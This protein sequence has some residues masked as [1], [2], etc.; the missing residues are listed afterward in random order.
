VRL[1]SAVKIKSIDARS[2]VPISR[3]R[4]FRVFA[5]KTLIVTTA[6]VL[7]IAL[8][9]TGCAPHSARTVEPVLIFGEPGRGDGQ[10]NMPRSVDFAR[11]GSVIVMDR[12]NRIQRFTPSG[13][14]LGA[15]HTETVKHGNPRGLSVAPN[16]EVFVADTHNSQVLVY[17]PQGRIA[18]RWGSYGMR[19]GQFVWVTD[20]AVDPRGPVYTCEYGEGRAD[21]LQKFDS[22]GRF[23]LQLARFGSR[24]GEVQR[25]QGLALDRQGNLYVADAVNH[26]VQEFAPD[27][28]L[29]AVIGTLGSAPGQLR[30]PYD[31]ALDAAGRLY[32]CEFGNHRVSVFGPEHRFLTMWGR[33]GRGPGEFNHPW[34]VG[35]DPAGFIYVADTYNYRVQKFAPLPP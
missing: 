10:F 11:D 16:G 23:V 21:R 4:P 30:Y 2:L 31:V 35:V 29:L 34:G 25:P 8:T 24:P 22:H 32:V 17:S 5:S 20:V 28:R 13:Q 7:P 19:P 18:R 27:G 26:R 14:Y 12:T 3:F 33:P 6:R 15:W 9:F 1:E